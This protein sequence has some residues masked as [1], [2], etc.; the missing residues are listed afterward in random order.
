MRVSKKASVHRSEDV[1]QLRATVDAL[2]A[3][4]EQLEGGSAPNGHESG[5]APQSRRDLLKLAGAAAAGA[6]GSIVLGSIP[7]AAANGDPITLGTSTGNDAGSTTDIYP[8]GGT[9]P[10]PL[11]QAT[12][13]GVPITTTVGPTLS[14]TVP[15]SQSLPLIGPI[16]AGGSLVPIGDP[17]VNDYPGFAP[18]QGIGGKA[19]VMT[20][21]GAKPVS[22]AINGF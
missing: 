11:F 22:E 1:A 20:S 9:A 13:Q 10:S 7:A 8:T 21:T 12:G 17:P 16:G 18:I 5:G 14:S 3:R 2:T 15:L 4:I 19:T 6:A